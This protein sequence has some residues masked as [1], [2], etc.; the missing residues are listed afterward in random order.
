MISTVVFKNSNDTSVAEQ[1]R[2]KLLGLPHH[3]E[4]MLKITNEVATDFNSDLKLS[5]SIL[6]QLF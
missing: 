3:P 5:K 1:I 6:Y 4:A 2:E